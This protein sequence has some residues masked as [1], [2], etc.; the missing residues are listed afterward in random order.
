VSASRRRLGVALLLD[1]PVADAVDGLRRAVGDPSIG[2]VAAHLT[3]VPP[4]NVAA[5]QLAAALAAVRAAAG[6]QDGPLQ[7]TLGPPATFLP[8]NPVLYLAVGGDLDALRRLRH[9][10]FVPPLQR[11]L[12]WPWVPHVTLADTASEARITGAVAALDRFAV[13]TSVDCITVL[14]E[15]RG[16]VWC[17]LA[18]AALGPPAVIGRG[19]LA[20]EIT[21]GR[22]LDPEVHAM[23]EAAGVSGREVTGSDLTAAG[24]TGPGSTGPGWHPAGPPIVLSARREGQ[25]AAAGMAWRSDA[26]GQVAVIVAPAARRQGVG[27]MVL[28]HLE[29]AVRGAEW[30]C[31]VLHAHGPAGFYRARSG[32]SVPVAATRTARRRTGPAS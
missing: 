26:G 5:G 15:G 31:P 25:V 12:T 17:P 19:G 11:T 32:W 21:R 16:R 24:S 6:G 30:E 7:L 18:D 22:I 14:E 27:G 1:Q 23:I 10:V 9:A 13:V 2:R 8:A 4:V 29:A 28:A 20:V 3:L